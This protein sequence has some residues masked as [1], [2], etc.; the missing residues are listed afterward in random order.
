M[1]TF[2]SRFSSRGTGPESWAPG[3]SRDACFPPQNRKPESA[4]PRSLGSICALFYLFLG[5][6][7]LHEFISFAGR[8]VFGDSIT[9]L[10]AAD[11]LFPPSCDDVQVVIG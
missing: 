9:L 1:F 8:N 6:E 4:L 10:Q 7:R 11:Q 2:L 3:L 5:C